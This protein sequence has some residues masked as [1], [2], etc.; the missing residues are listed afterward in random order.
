MIPKRFLQQAKQILQDAKQAEKILE[1][2]K[3]KLGEKGGQVEKIKEDLQ[4][5]MRMIRAYV[6]RDYK[7][8]P[9][10]SLVALTAGL[11]Y[12]LNPFDL[13]PDFLLGGFLDDV[14]IIGLIFS[15]LKKDLDTFSAWE[16]K[17]K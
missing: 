5:V 8:V 17:R 13:I 12:F 2:A 16:K 11:L 15:N 6:K 4:T 14:T 10:T 7:E 3:K 9:W 1:D